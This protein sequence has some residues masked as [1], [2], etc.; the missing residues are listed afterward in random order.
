LEEGS[1]ISQR[2]IVAESEGS[3][4]ERLTH[5]AIR[6]QERS[7]KLIGL[8]FLGVCSGPRLVVTETNDDV[9]V[10]VGPAPVQLKVPKLMGERKAL[11]VR[12][13]CPM[14]AN[15]CRVTLPNQYARAVRPEISLLDSDAEMLGDAA[16]VH[17]W[18]AD[19][20][21]AK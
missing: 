10:D 12:W 8:A 9:F 13:M 3:N 20:G 4:R 11:S 14:H 16:W 18:F 6:H 5:P 1:K 2:R 21:H 7:G 17:R 19:S 15:D